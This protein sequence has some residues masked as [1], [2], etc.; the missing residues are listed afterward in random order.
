MSED[1]DN[2]LQIEN[3]R[4]LLVEN[5]C[6]IASS[7]LL[8]FDAVLTLPSECCWIWGCGISLPTMIYLLT[9]YLAV[10]ERVFFVLQPMLLNIDNKVE[11]AYYDPTQWGPPY[12]C[13]YYWNISDD[14]LSKV[15]LIIQ[16]ITITSNLVGNSLAIWLVWPYFDQVVTVIL[17]SRLMLGLH[18]INYEEINEEES[19]QTQSNIGFMISMSKV[20]ANLDSNGPDPTASTFPYS[21][22]TTSTVSPSHPCS[23]TS[24]R[25]GGDQVSES[26]RD[27]IEMSTRPATGIPAGQWGTE[28]A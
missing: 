13:G 23:P 25:A 27:W 19:A 12:G 3:A 22:D 15:L 21:S 16:V 6:I 20:L 17:L 2:A 10:I 14:L 9:K 18:K 4:R 1:S 5:Y 7:T 11:S 28:T 26:P 8:W 24:R